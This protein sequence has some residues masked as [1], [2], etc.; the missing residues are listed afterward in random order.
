MATGFGLIFSRT[1]SGRAPVTKRFHVPA[2]DSTAL[3]KGDVVELVNTTGSMDTAG[4]FQDVTRATSGHILLGVIDGFK[5]DGSSPYKGNYRAASTDAYVDVIVDPDAIYEAQED[6]VGGSITAALVGAMTNVNM[7]VA[8]GSTVTGY[9]GTM[10][11][12]STT[13]ASAADLKV[14]GVNPDGG[15]NV[16]AKSGGAVLEVMILAPAMKS[17]DSQS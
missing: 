12:S 11:D 17:T 4:E 6:A 10:I 16:A 7:V 2:T 15:N 5:P 14:V 3:F 13:T 1:L 8:N 9:S